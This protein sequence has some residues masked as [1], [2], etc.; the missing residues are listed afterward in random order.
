VELISINVSLPKEIDHN[1]THIQTSIFKQAV[2][3]D[4]AVNQLN[5]AGDQQSDLKNHGGE[6]K[7]IYGFSAGHYNFWRHKLN[8]PSLHYGQFGEN[9][10]ITHLDEASLCIGDR[11]QINDCVLE[12]TQPR[13]PCFK[14]G[15]AFDLSTMQELFIQHA[16][17]GIYFRVLQTGSIHTGNKV[18]RIHQHP[19]QLSVQTLFK[20]YFDK[21]FVDPETVLKQAAGIP[22]LSNE[23]RQKVVTRINNT[24]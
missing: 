19:E 14:L 18:E 9:L 4:I 5:L 8:N 21:N 17:T 13:V 15:I 22:E 3:G 7:A 20:A 6:H 2:A 10:T 16:A 11:I 1:N 23:W 12:I 24:Q